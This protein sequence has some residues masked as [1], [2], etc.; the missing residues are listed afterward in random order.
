VIATAIGRARRRPVAA[1]ALAVAVVWLVL[2]AF[3]TASSDPWEHSGG[4]Y[5]LVLDIADASL[6]GLTAIAAFA[7]ML[8]RSRLVG[9]R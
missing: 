3:E 9:R 7:W 2:V 4:W 1:V 5:A 8:E 6:W